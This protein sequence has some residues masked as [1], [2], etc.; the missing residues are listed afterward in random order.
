MSYSTG[1]VSS[2]RAACRRSIPFCTTQHQG[3]EG[4]HGSGGRSG[5]SVGYAFLQGKSGTRQCSRNWGP[6]SSW[7]LGR[8]FSF[9]F[10]SSSLMLPFIAKQQTKIVR[11]TNTLMIP[12]NG[13]R[14]AVNELSYK[15]GDGCKNRPSPRECSPVL[16]VD[17][18][19]VMTA[20]VKHCSNGHKRNIYVYIYIKKIHYFHL[21]IKKHFHGCFF[22]VCHICK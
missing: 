6:D 14:T 18:H 2:H 10:T 19:T 8:F 17:I 5:S 3:L 15:K 1:N 9:F 7:T 21:L 22:T 4:S 20:N 12:T 13:N 16:F 11:K